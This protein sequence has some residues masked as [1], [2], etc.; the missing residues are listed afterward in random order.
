MRQGDGPA[1]EQALAN[2]ECRAP[3]IACDAPRRIRGKA[4]GAGSIAVRVAERVKAEDCQLGPGAH[5]EVCDELVL[6]EN[7]AGLKLVLRHRVDAY[8]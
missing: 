4:G 2:V 8:Y 7:S 6:I 5:I 1:K 3:V